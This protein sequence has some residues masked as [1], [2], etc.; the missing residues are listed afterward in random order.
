MESQTLLL[1]STGVALVFLSLVFILFMHD[2][3]KKNVFII[4]HGFED[5][6]LVKERKKSKR[7][8]RVAGR[9]VSSILSWTVTVVLVGVLAVVVYGSF[10][11]NNF[12][13]PG[14]GTV[15]A[16][17][18]GSMKEQNPR[19]Q[20]LKEHKVEIGNLQSFNAND[21]IKLHALPKESEIKLGRIYSYIQKDTGNLIIHRLVDINPEEGLYRFQGD[22]NP[23]R[24]SQIVKYSE[25][26]G[27]Y[28]GGR[29]PTLGSFVL[30]FQ[31]PIGLTTV[32][33]GMIILIGADI[34]VSKIG[35][36]EKTRL[37]LVQN[38][39]YYVNLALEDDKANKKQK[40]NK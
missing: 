16:V 36:S 4:N 23:V 13:I 26:R 1:I 25:M 20:F 11:S 12:P 15:V 19:N 30:F 21:L 6:R 22:A 27:E 9:V 31:S 18:T 5:H 29:I 14:V 10:F 3:V 35:K 34:G 38:D 2:M 40:K 17:R 24:D 28:K 8:A 33:L 32:V 7:P 39:P 37:D